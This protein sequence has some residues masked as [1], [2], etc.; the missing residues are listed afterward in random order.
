MLLLWTAAI[1]SDVFVWLVVYSNYQE[2]SDITRLEDMAKL[3]M[4]TL[5]SLNASRSF[6][7]HS[8]DSANPYGRYGAGP[9]SVSQSL[10]A[11]PQIYRHGQAPPPPPPGPSA[12]AL[13]E[14][15]TNLGYPGGYGA[16]ASRHL[17]SVQAHPQPPSRGVAAQSQKPLSSSQNSLHANYLQMY[18]S[19]L[20]QR[21]RHSSQASLQSQNAFPMTTYSQSGGA[22][23]PGPSSGAAGYNNNNSGQRNNQAQ[24]QHQ[25]QYG[26]YGSMRSNFV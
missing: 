4:S 16:S 15:H 5:S 26:A 6:S 17:A 21:S 14:S 10:Q 23:V 2:L 9:S 12:M 1:M 24:A 19:T 22:A 8:L 25:P 7:H 13:H 18:S 20:S 3:K 11:S